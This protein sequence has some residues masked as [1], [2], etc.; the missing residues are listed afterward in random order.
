MILNLKE[1]N[2]FIVY[3]HFKMDSLKTVKDLMSQGCYM[4]S[5]DIK[6]AYYTVPIATEHQKILKFSGGTN[7]I[8]IH[9]PASK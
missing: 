7:C 1:L 9:V 4:A 3:R 8:K 2:K 5:V 6:D